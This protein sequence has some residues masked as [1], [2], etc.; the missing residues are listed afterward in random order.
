M[1]QPPFAPLRGL[2]EWLGILPV[3][4]CPFQRAGTN[5]VA[6]ASQSTTNQTRNHPTEPNPGRV[7]ADWGPRPPIGI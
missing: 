3:S 6:Q 4:L 7:P 2:A 1:H 5:L